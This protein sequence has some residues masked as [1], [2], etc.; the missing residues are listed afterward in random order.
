M[1]F[2]NIQ[3]RVEKS[4]FEV[5]RKRLVF[6]N[7]LPDI[8][9]GTRYPVNGEQL[10]PEASANWDTDLKTIQGIKGFASEVF[11]HGSDHAKGLKRTPRISIVPRRMMPGEIGFNP[12]GTILQDA[13]DPDNMIKIGNPL[14]SSNLALDIILTSSTAKQERFLNALVATVVG[15]KNYLPFYDSDFEVFFIKQTSWYDLPNETEGIEEKVFT[16]EATDFYMFDSA[17]IE[18]VNLI[19]EITVNT[20]L[21]ELRSIVTANS[22]IIGPYINDGNLYID[23]SGV[24]FN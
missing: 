24:K 5:I 20:T 6:E 10:T 16:Y 17:N 1:A 3:E 8:N 15:H 14:E 22:V 21:L 13:L 4:I 12:G 2:N 7:V 19:K 9:D 23:L 18:A 11:G